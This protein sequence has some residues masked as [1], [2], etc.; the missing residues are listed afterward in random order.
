MAVH[1]DLKMYNQYLHDK[2]NLLNSCFRENDTLL[3]KASV[4]FA[5][6]FVI[7]YA[8]LQNKRKSSDN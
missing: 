5:K 1:R 2:A 3:M 7:L 4:A 8:N 6:I